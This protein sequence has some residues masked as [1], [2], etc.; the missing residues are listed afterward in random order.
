MV[1][2]YQKHYYKCLEL[3]RKLNNSFSDLFY[4]RANKFR[5]KAYDKQADYLA[6]SYKLE[7]LLWVMGA[8]YEL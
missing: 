1:K 6:T 5:C 3:R 8:D 2:I 7:T 4:N